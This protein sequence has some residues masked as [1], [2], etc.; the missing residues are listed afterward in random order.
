MAGKPCL[1]LFHLLGDLNKSQP[2][3][4]RDIELGLGRDRFRQ[5]DGTIGAPTA[6][7][8]QQDRRQ[9]KPPSSL[10]GTVHKSFQ[11]GGGQGE[12]RKGGQKHEAIVG[13]LSLIHI[14]EPTRR[15][16]ISYAVF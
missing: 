16:P 6:K 5:D 3:W 10:E 7:S 9:P 14:S 11:P 8:G 12:N 15:T 4:I 13:H 1:N 2:F